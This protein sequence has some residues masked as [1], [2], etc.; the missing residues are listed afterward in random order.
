MFTRQSVKK[1][2]PALEEAIA[3][4]DW[5]SLGIEKPIIALGTF[6]F[7]HDGSNMRTKIDLSIPQKS[8]NLDDAMVRNGM[9]K[10]GDV[11]GFH[12]R[13]GYNPFTVKKINRTRYLAEDENG[14][15]WAIPMRDCRVW[16]EDVLEV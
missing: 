9:A 7:A 1:V 14:K 5:A 2:R 6:N 16:D 13:N 15:T 12:G 3:D 11:V 10:A 8:A 4:T